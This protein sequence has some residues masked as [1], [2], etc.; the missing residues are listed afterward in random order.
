[1][2]QAAVHTPAD[3]DVERGVEH[4]MAL[5]PPM[6]KDRKSVRIQV[7]DGVVTLSGHVLTPNTRDFMLSRIPNVPGVTAINTDA[8]YDD[9]SVRL[10]VA[11]LLPDGVRLA[12]VQY[13]VLVLTGT[14]PAGMTTEQL[15]ARIG[16]VPGVE[17]IIMQFE[18]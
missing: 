6:V 10:N 7:Q 18:D 5:Y 14:L 4:L 13:G 9:V 17:H 8:L 2:S 3:I 15:A 12:R 16:A 1:M 11:H